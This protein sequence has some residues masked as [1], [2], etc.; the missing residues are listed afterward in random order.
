M[1][2]N[3]LVFSFNSK[4][5]VDNALKIA[6]QACEEALGDYDQLRNEEMRRDTYALMKSFQNNMKLFAK[7]PNNNIEEI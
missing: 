5:K 1:M 2:L 4:S 6:K 3:Y 7:G